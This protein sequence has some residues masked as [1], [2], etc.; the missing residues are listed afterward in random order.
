MLLSFVSEGTGCKGIMGSRGRGGEGARGRGGEIERISWR[1]NK[2]ARNV[3]FEL[4]K[5]FRGPGEKYWNNSN[6][7]CFYRNS[8]IPRISRSP[9]PGRRRKKGDIFIT[10]KYRV[11]ERFCNFSF[12]FVKRFFVCT[13]FI[14]AY[15]HAYHLYNMPQ[16]SIITMH[17]LCILHFLV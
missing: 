14:S 4:R 17:L 2:R 10:C 9:L 15:N 13:S 5:M 3:Y 8:R 1:R 6:A 16:K 12:P 11:H 7:Q